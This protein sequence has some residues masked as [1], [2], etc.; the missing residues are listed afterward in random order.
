MIQRH[1]GWLFLSHS[2]K[3]YELVRQVRNTLEE[4]GFRPIMFFLKCLTDRDELD[5][6]IY[7]EIEARRWFVFLDSEN[8][9]A[10]KWAQ[11]ELAYAEALKKTIFTIDASRDYLPQLSK[12]IRQTSVF[13]SYSHRDMEIAAQIRDAL[14][15][16]DF[17]VWWD[18]PISPGTRWQNPIEHLIETAGF[19]LLLIT[20]NSLESKYITLEIECA[21]YKERP[22]IPVLIGDV[23]LPPDMH[24][25]LSP[26]QF[27]RLSSTPTPSELSSLIDNI[28]QYQEIHDL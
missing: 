24:L 2:T 14:V 27:E 18:I 28:I 21:L 6:L 23:Q 10:S 26:F 16:N 11:D 7:R 13:L 3:D 9:R 20:Q 22:V 25:L 19:C 1:D 8:S 4:H 17:Q 15:A 12:I 5:D